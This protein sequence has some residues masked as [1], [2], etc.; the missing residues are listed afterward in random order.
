MIYF[1]R[2][3]K[4][5]YSN[6]IKENLCKNEIL[7]KLTTE[8]TRLHNKLNLSDA[9]GEFDEISGR[10]KGLDFA[11]SILLSTDNSKSI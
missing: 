5:N 1:K 7:E 4:M 2:G 10:I 6:N 11:K 9:V 3:K 8:I